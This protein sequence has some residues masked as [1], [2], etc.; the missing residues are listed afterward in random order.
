MRR[1]RRIARGTVALVVMACFLTV[2]C[3]GQMTQSPGQ[4]ALLCGA[5]GAVAGAAV[6]GAVGKSWQGAL[7]GAALGAMAAGVSCFAFADYKSRQTADYRQTQQTTGYQPAQGDS[8]QITHY[9]ITPAAAAPGSSVSFN[10]TY[11]VM[12][13]DPNA[14][15]SVTEV[16]SLYVYDTKINNWKELGRVPNQVTV[17]PGTRQADGKFDVRSGV[18]TGNYRVVFQVAKDSLTDTKTL[19]LIVTNDRQVLNSSQALVAQVDAP[20]AK[21]MVGAAPE[22]GTQTTASTP[23]PAPAA[24][25]DDPRAGRPLSSLGEQPPAAPSTAVASA[26]PSGT[27]GVAYFVASRLTGPGT[28]RAGPGSIHSVVGTIAVGERYPIVERATPTGQTWYKIRL[29]SGAEAWVSAALGD[30]VR[31]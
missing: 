21:P 17:K 6:G 13:P 18:A 1:K 11:T 10:A 2:S 14:D 22:P 27:T 4:M 23:S 8:V 12:T 26:P 31:Q 7:V 5:G 24:A 19:P 29:D 20:G 30:E 9:E 15:V 25:P 16:R 3:A 28:L